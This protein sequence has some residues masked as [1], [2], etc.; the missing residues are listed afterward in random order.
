M[1]GILDLIQSAKR[2]ERT[3]E[4]CLR[5]DLTAEYE[6]LERQLVD[7]RSNDSRAF[8]GGEARAVAAKMDALREQ[9]RTSTVVFRLRSLERMRPLS[10]LAE[11][12]PRD[13]NDNDKRLGYNTETYYP[14]MIRECCYAVERAGEELGA[15]QLSD[16][17]WS[18]LFDAL[19]HKQFDRLFSAAWVLNDDDVSVPSSALASL[20][21]Q[22]S[23]ESSKQ[24]EPG[25]SRR[26][27]S[28]GGNRRKSPK[29]SATK[30]AG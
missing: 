7:A 17:D 21:S 24:P 29:S 15:D 11:H 10:L 20:I 5:G 25:E 8:T 26:S 23:G 19:S 28:A 30:K 18:A 9:M 4:L 3:V 2:P 13:G 6:E 27:G 14:A 22:A 12:Q 16:E 1:N